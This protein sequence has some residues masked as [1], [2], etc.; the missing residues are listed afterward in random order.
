MWYTSYKYTINVQ[1]DFLI[2]YF[3]YLLIYYGI[4]NFNILF[5]NKYWS[6]QYCLI[7]E[8]ILPKIFLY[9]YRRQVLKNKYNN[10]D[11][12]Y[13]M[14]IR[15]GIIYPM[16]IWIFRYQRWLVVNWFIFQPLKLKIKKYRV[17]SQI[18][19][20]YTNKNYMFLLKRLHYIISLYKINIYNNFF[21]YKF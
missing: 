20:L 2:K 12:S 9:Y 4:Y 19:Y 21:Y 16:R 3:F 10:A 1:H 14:R 15:R 6:L 17:S 13:L 5:F 8:N 7:H 18:D 11:L